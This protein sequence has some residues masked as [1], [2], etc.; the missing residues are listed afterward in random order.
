MWLHRLLHGSIGLWPAAAWLFLY[1]HLLVM[2]FLGY[3]FTLGA[4]LV[5]FAA[6]IASERWPVWLRLTLFPM[7]LVAVFFGHLFPLAIY[8]ICVAA[9]EFRKGLPLLQ[10]D[11]RR[12]ARQWAVGAWQFLP[13]GLLVLATM[14]DA[15]ERSFFYGPF[16]AKVRMLWSPV[17]TWYKPID[18]VLILFVL[19]VLVAGL[20]TRRL[21]LAPGLRLPVAILA[22]LAAAMPFWIEGAWGSIWYADLRLPLALALLLVAGLRPCAVSPK[23]ALAVGCAAAVLFTARVADVAIDWRA[24]DGD[25]GEFRAALGVIEPGASLLPVQKR[26]AAP[27]GGTQ[28][29]DEAYWH[30]PMLAVIDRS[31]FVPTLFTDPTKQPV[32][33]APARKDMDTEFGAP[34]GLALLVDSAHGGS[35]VAGGVGMKS[36]W[37]DWPRRYDYVL[38]THFGAKGNPLADLLAPTYEGSFFD[39]YR[40]QRAE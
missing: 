3:L 34:I 20:V 4:A 33:A 40:V 2:G 8:G 28:Q 18:A 26:D 38:I 30:M 17:L 11:R 36:F 13:T 10:Q 16:L 12:A 29:F 6:W 32:R 14:P 39:I 5:L 1:N 35:A 21:T 37:Q 25:Y 24:V 19:G 31:A 7:A 15:G 22:A 27:D 9:W 23:L